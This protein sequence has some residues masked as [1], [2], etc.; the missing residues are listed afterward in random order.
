MDN[1]IMTILIGFVGLV[2]GFLIAKIMEKK[3]ASKTMANAK[4]EADAI[5]KAA[6]IDPT[7]KVIN[8]FIDRSRFYMKNPPDQSWKGYENLKHK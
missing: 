3:K 5:I 4:S 2:A 6:K 1:T 7:D 8:I